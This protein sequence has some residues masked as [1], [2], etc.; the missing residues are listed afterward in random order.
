[1]PH[2]LAPDL[3]LHDARQV[4]ADPLALGLVLGLD[5]HAHQRLRS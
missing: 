5:H 4:G 3:D 2:T 1:M